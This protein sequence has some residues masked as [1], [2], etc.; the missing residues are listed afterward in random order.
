MKSVGDSVYRGPFGFYVRPWVNGRRTWKKLNSISQAEAKKEARELLSDHQRAIRGMGESPFAKSGTLAELAAKYIAAGCPSKSHPIRPAVF[1]AGEKDRIEWLLKKLGDL[2]ASEIRPGDCLEYGPWRM[3]LVARGTGKRKADMELQTLSNIFNYGVMLGVK[4]GG[5]EFNFIRGNKPRFCKSADVRHCSK[6]KLRSADH[7]H[8]IADRFFESPQHETTGFQLLYAALTGCRKN[9]L[10]ALRA[11]ADYQEPGYMDAHYLYVR[12]SKGNVN[13]FVSLD[14]RINPGL[15][16]LVEAWRYWHAERY[17]Q[18]PHFFPGI[19]P[20]QPLCQEALGMALKRACKEFK[21]PHC[22]PHGLRAFYVQVQRSLGRSD[23]EIGAM[24][25]HSGGK[26]I[27]TTY[28]DRCVTEKLSFYPSNGLPAWSKW[29][30]AEQKM[31][32][33]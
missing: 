4:R 25:G 2:Q 20:R 22:T 32:G 28:G 11:D 23:E 5:V 9:E 30:P 14:H 16:E 29:R 7:L 27:R 6:V 31:V 17:P 10:L 18:S 12:R 8:R 13:P 24:I 21:L 1:I 15:K 3:R 33:I 19:D 26:L